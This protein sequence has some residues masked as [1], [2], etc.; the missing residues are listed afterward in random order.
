MKRTVIIIVCSL[1][2]I[3]SI[4]NDNLAKLDKY[5]IYS[6]KDY[7]DACNSLNNNAVPSV[8]NNLRATSCLSFVSGLL[9]GYQSTLSLKAEF[10]LAKN[11]K[12]NRKVISSQIDSNH[13]LHEELTELTTQS[14][15]LC[16]KQP[17]DLVVIANNTLNSLQTSKVDEDNSVHYYVLNEIEKQLTCDH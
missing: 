3:I 9:V 5:M 2:P 13:K 1:F 14:E 17:L 8:E 6:V 4:A 12:V 7:N 15:F 10:D 16:Y 11:K